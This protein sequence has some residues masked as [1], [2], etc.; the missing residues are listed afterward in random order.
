MVMKKLMYIVLVLLFSSLISDQSYAKSREEDTCAEALGFGEELRNFYTAKNVFFRVPSYNNADKMTQLYADLRNRADLYINTS[1]HKAASESDISEIRYL[2][3]NDVPVDVRG[4]GGATPLSVAAASGHIEAIDIFLEL[5]ADINAPD[6]TGNS[7]LIYGVRSGR[8]Y[9]VEHLLRKGADVNLANLMDEAPTMFAVWL[10]N[11]DMLHALASYGADL[12]VTNTEGWTLLHAAVTHLE[13]TN[14]VDMIETI[15][16]TITT[17][18]EPRIIDWPDRVYGNTPLHW[19]AAYGHTD[20]IHV[21]LQ[22]G[23]RL[24]IVNKDG[25][26]PIHVAARTDQAESFLILKDANP[27]LLEAVDREG[28][29]PI[30]IAR[31]HNSERVLSDLGL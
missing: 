24:D 3:F 1:L 29:T 26:L 13:V 9:I 17:W 2:V 14:R 7:S 8:G 16:D 27:I 25:E 4:P 31:A 18:P 30:D 21:L 28:Q 22:R 20:V 12:I 23:A 5:G 15:L 19:A 6:A 10:G 11:E